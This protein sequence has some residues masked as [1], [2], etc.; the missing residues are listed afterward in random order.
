MAD[1]EFIDANGG[2]L[3]KRHRH[4]LAEPLPLS[5]KSGNKRLHIWLPSRGFGP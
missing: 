4:E 1:P 2:G 3:R 5:V